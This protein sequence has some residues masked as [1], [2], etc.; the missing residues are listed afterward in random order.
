M[1][2]EGEKADKDEE[3]FEE[4]EVAVESGIYRVLK[5]RMEDQGV[6]ED[7]IVFIHDYKTDEAREDLFDEVR[8]GNIRV[9]IGSTEKMGVGVNVQDRAA[10]LHHVDAP[11]R[12]R[13]IEQR[14]G[15]IVRQENI[16]YGPE[17]DAE[18]KN[19]L[20]PGRGVQVYQ[21]VQKGGLDTFMWQ[22]LEEKGRGIKGFMKRNIDPGELKMQEVDTLVLTAAETK[23]AASAN[24]LVSKEVELGNAIRS[25]QL[26]RRAHDIRR[27]TVQEEIGTLEG[28]VERA[29]RDLPMLDRDAAHVSALPKDAKFAA[30]VGGARY[31]KSGEAGEALA[32][33]VIN[34]PRDRDVA[35]A[36]PIGEYKG[37][38]IGGN[39]LESGYRIT[40]ERPGGLAHTIHFA[41]KDE[42]TPAGIFRRIGHTIGNTPLQ[43]AEI[44]SRMT[45][46]ED[47]L[48]QVRQEATSTWD[49][50]PELYALEQEHQE[51]RNRLQRGET[52]DEGNVVYGLQPLPVT[53]WTPA[54]AAGV[55]DRFKQREGGKDD[56]AP[57]DAAQV[58]GQGGG[59]R[60]G[61][62]HAR[63]ERGR[64]ARACA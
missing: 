57:A 11:W 8:K 38:Q 64:D 24:P 33:A 22:A 29:Q 37:F 2:D 31:D 10:A 7:Q 49:S 6:P 55:A 56:A 21:Y 27:K 43:A 28:V 46:S 62:A 34:L 18:K 5:E 3:A 63:G 4:Q 50:A 41:T 45:I 9:V 52:G 39:R 17:M 25:L 20:S 58:R 36:R 26:D 53:G 61:H 59:S 44:R 40:I 51:I 32:G 47:R 35:D 19:V 15:R 48:G 42:V 60:T 13:D 16:A 14:E 54:D 23:A 12:P 30:K 1:K